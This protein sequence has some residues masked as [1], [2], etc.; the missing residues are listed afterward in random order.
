MVSNTPVEC[1][2][3]PEHA[4]N[5]NSSSLP[6]VS[7]VTILINVEDKI[8]LILSAIRKLL[9]LKIKIEHRM[10]TLNQQIRSSNHPFI[11]NN[12]S[13]FSTLKSLKIN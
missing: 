11:N 12:K 1:T 5:V 13:H 3:D 2:I 6:T 4:D 8:I 9:K 7:S 10:I